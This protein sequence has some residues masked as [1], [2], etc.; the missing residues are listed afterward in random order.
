MGGVRQR[1]GEVRNDDDGGIR[2]TQSCFQAQS[3]F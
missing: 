1:D 3:C 2:V